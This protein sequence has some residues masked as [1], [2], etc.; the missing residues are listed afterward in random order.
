MMVGSSL[1]PGL[2]RGLGILNESE[3]QDVGET[4]SNYVNVKPTIRLLYEINTVEVRHGRM[5]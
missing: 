4:A 1:L 3:T 2:W 5:C